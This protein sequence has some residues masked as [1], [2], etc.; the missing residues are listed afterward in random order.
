MEKPTDAQQKELNKLVGP[1]LRSIIF[2]MLNHL[3]LLFVMNAI[4]LMGHDTYFPNSSML[5]VYAVS[6]LVAI[7]TMRR[8][9]LISK[10]LRVKLISDCEIIL[11][12]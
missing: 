10:E 3:G 2:N 12:K 8:M 9:N 11:K 1:Y 5:N 7:F 6:V 4:A